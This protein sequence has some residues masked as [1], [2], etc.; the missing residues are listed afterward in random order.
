MYAPLQT[1]P[2]PPWDEN[3]LPEDSSYDLLSSCRLNNLLSGASDTSGGS[4]DFAHTVDD[5]TLANDTDIWMINQPLPTVEDIGLLEPLD[6]AEVRAPESPT[7]NDISH[8]STEDQA[9]L[10]SQKVWELPEPTVQKLL[11]ESFFLYVHPSYPVVE[12]EHVWKEFEN[13]VTN[14][15]FLV[16]RAILCTAVPVRTQ[17]S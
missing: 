3:S 10:S 16:Y 13:G 7:R 2:I 14:M 15:S 6:T 9:Y 11:L 12:E 17:I 5:R 8:L 1:T 4:L